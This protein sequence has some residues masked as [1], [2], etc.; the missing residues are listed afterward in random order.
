[1]KERASR[2]E[3]FRFIKL[4]KS[5]QVDGN[6]DWHACSV[7]RQVGGVCRSAQEAIENSRKLWLCWDFNVQQNKAVIS[8]HRSC[9]VEGVRTTGEIPIRTIKIYY[10]KI[11]SNYL[12]LLNY[13]NW[14]VSCSELFCI[15]PPNK[16]NISSTEAL[17]FCHDHYEIFD[18]R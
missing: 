18:H 8:I 7:V 3:G 14:I 13:L 1:M 11:N 5:F 17:Q 10:R 2:G 6:T 15:K 16:L 9:K 4:G 12:T